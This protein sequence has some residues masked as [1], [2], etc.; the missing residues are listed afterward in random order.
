MQPSLELKIL[1]KQPY[2]ERLADMTNRYGLLISDEYLYD[3]QIG[4][5]LPFAR[6]ANGVKLILSLGSRPSGLSGVSK[7]VKLHSETKW[8]VL[9]GRGWGEVRS[10][11]CFKFAMLSNVNIHSG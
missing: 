10:K 1:H 11:Y 6:S 3:V 9:G 8:S 7:E 5:C 2:N 4:G